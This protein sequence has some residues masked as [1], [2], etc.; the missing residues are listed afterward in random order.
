MRERGFV[1]AS[2][3]SPKPHL[4]DSPKATHQIQ[5]LALTYTQ[6]G[7]RLTAGSNR[8]ESPHQPFFLQKMKSPAL[9]AVTFTPSSRIESPPP[10]EIS[11]SLPD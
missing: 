8:N 7:R 5:G 1:A 4:A 11:V 10:Q 2:D 3:D 6:T 9:R